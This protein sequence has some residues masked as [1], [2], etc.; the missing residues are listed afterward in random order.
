MTTQPPKPTPAPKPEVAAKTT[1]NARLNVHK[2]TISGYIPLNTKDTKTIVAA[3]D[4]VNNAVEALK[5]VS[6]VIT[7]EETAF[8]TVA[9]D[10]G[11]E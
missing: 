7:R 11:E 8:T 10:T 1:P 4:A 5:K 9:A 3:V 2:F 6:G